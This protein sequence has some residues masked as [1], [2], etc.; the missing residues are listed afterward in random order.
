MKALELPNV[1]LA[2]DEAGNG[3]TVV[4]LHTAGTS[5]RQWRRIVP[6]LAQRFRVITVDL[7]GYGGTSPWRSG[8]KPRL[9]ADADLIHGLVR[10]IGGPAHLAGH[11]YG[12]SVALR[13]GLDRADLYNGITAIEPVSFH[14]LRKGLSGDREIFM[15]A[16]TLALDL[17]HAATDGP[18]GAGRKGARKFVRFFSG[19]DTWAQISEDA[20]RSIRQ[21]LMPIACN[22]FA[23]SQDRTILDD[24]VDYQLPVR[25]ITGDRTVQ[26]VR[27]VAE[28]MR[29][30]IPGAKQDWLIAAGHMAATSSHAE[31]V[32][33]LIADHAGVLLPLPGGGQTRAA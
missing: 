8:E 2:Y 17:A 30:Y 31:A 26:P 19:P 9:S 21:R 10:H 12:A 25:L 28:R 4:L 24:Y 23:V 20:R 6:M 11:G 3:R 27:R 18:G 7:R 33:E 32:S 5:S 22:V 14:L 15:N 13:A 29:S 1:R 16:A